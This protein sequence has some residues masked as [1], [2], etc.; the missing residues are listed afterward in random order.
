VNV[1]DSSGWLEYF[2]GTSRAKHFAGAIED[3]KSL[4]VPTVSLLE[5]FK[6]VLE[7]RGENDA[8]QAVALMQQGA[9]VELTAVL[10]IDAARLGK[11]LHL[12]LAD[13]IMLASARHVGAVLWTQDADFKD[14]PD[15]K[16]FPKS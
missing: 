6:R 2:A 3:V 14:I 4:F 7:Q 12:P 16:Y 9:S 13:S 1:V 10:A 11:A 15:V 5:V 8:L